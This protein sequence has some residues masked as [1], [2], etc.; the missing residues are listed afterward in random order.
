MKT[1]VKKLNHHEMAMIKG[2]L[3]SKTSVEKIPSDDCMIGCQFN[4]EAM[5]DFQADYEMNKIINTVRSNKAFDH[6]GA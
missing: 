5:N 6:I 3:L 1:Y 2:G 4:E